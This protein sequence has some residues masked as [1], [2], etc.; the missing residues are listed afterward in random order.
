MDPWTL[1]HITALKK[2]LEQQRSDRKNP[3]SNRSRAELEE[4]VLF[5]SLM[6]RA[7]LEILIKKGLTS[8]KQLVEEMKRLDLLDGEADHGLDTKT[9]AND[10]GVPRPDK[11]S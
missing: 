8:K 2:D 1:Q 11:H 4:D 5:L 7:L 9:L 3:P 6:N 10:L